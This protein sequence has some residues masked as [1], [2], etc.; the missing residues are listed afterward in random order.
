MAN[1]AGN[2]SSTPGRQVQKGG[3]Q[4]SSPTT[5][6]TPGDGVGGFIQFIG[7]VVVGLAGL[8]LLAGLNNMSSYYSS[9]DAPVQIGL[10]VAAIIQGLLLVGFGRLISLT[11]DLKFAAQRSSAYLNQGARDK[12]IVS[13][14]EELKA[15]AQRSENYLA[16]AVKDL[17]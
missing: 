9:D 11:G 16:Q 10:A 7:W 17:G 15:S 3:G 14:L 5:K 8:G 12:Q 2:T 13:I 4:K 6:V 1:T